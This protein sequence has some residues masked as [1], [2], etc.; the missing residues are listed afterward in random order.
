MKKWVKII[1]SV[2]IAI[3]LVMAGIFLIN[4]LNGNKPSSD[5]TVRNNVKYYEEDYTVKYATVLD[6]MFSTGWS[7]SSKEKKRDE[8]EGCI[9]TDNRDIDYYLWVIEYTDFKG[10][11]RVFELNN[12]IQLSDQIEDYFTDW[13]ANYYEIKYVNEYM[14]D[15]PIYNGSYTYTFMVNPSWGSDDGWSQADWDRVRDSIDRYV[16][17]FGTVEGAIDF[18]TLVPE[19]V[20]KDYPVHLSVH[21]ALDDEKDGAIEKEKIDKLAKERVEAMINKIA[22]NT[23]GDFNAE[24]S[25]NSMLCRSKLYNNET[26]WRWSY[27]KGEKMSDTDDHKLYE[28]YKKQCFEK[29]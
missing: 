22:E 4:F 18:S 5:Y 1:L 8:I 13:I 20:F 10:D 29:E 6:A 24:F 15:I 25:V 28:A 16:E 23:N 12:H 11:R 7:V 2:I 17:S 26:Y 19:K 3:A 14:K 9:H 21:I 27:V